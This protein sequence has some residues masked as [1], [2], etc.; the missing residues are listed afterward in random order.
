[1][2]KTGAWSLHT[3]SSRSEVVVEEEA[4]EETRCLVSDP[5]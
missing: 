5:N 1:M 3:V 2:A 4:T